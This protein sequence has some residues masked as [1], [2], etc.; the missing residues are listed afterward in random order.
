MMTKRNKLSR[1]KTLAVLV[2]VF[3]AAFITISLNVWGQTIKPRL[4]VYVSTMTRASAL[5]KELQRALPETQIK[6][7]SRVRDF[8][9]AVADESPEAVIARHNL[10]KGVK[11]TPGVQGVLNGQKAEPYVLLSVDKSIDVAT[12]EGK[13]VG[14]VD[15]LGRRQTATF[16]EKSLGVKPM[17][18]RTVKVEDL[19]A[20][21]QFSAADAILL[22]G[23][24]TSV[25]Q[26]TSQLKLV[27]TS[28]PNASM[29]LPAAGFSSDEAKNAISPLIK[30]LNGSINEKLGVDSWQ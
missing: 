12:L 29:P 6:V 20:L 21:L 3:L 24:F 22:P 7:F 27:E 5:Q 25:L 23:R 8:E 9:K 14:A 30:K 26:K 4:F 1:H 18:K 2:P 19:L 10:V 17:I 15:E 28:L 16:V 13:N 11:M